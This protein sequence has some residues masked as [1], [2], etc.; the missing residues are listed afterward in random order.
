MHGDASACVDEGERPAR[1]ADGIQFAKLSV[2]WR[3]HARPLDKYPPCS[4]PLKPC[5]V[6]L[7][8]APYVSQRVLFLLN[9][10]RR[11]RVHPRIDADHSCIALCLQ[12]VG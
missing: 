1:F 12:Q 4:E 2:T 9:P 8:P 7:V 11:W 3:G 5:G 6:E 10:S